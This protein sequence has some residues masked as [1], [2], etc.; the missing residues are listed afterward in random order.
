MRRPDGT[1]SNPLHGEILPPVPGRAQANARAGA[2][3]EDAD[4]TNAKA[5][6]VRDNFWTALKRVVRQVPFTTDLVA[7]YYCA[8]DSS[9][10]F[11]VRATLLGALAYFILPID[12][13]PDFIV[14]LGY[15]DD[16]AVLALAI[17]RVAGHITER[18]REAARAT[19]A[20]PAVTGGTGPSH[21]AAGRAR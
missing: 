8:M 4:E 12:V 1:P 3:A 14:G 2:H 15:T 16:A 7:A 17:R 19:L 9:T 13:I 6:H 21:G 5:Q 20:D 11:R 18:H 10:P